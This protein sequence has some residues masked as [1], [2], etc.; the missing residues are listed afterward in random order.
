MLCGGL[1]GETT[2]FM[3]RVDSEGIL[4]QDPGA[5]PLAETSWSAGFSGLPGFKIESETPEDDMKIHARWLQTTNQPLAALAFVGWY[6]M[7][8]GRCSRY[9]AHGSE[10]IHE[11][12]D[13]DYT[14]YCMTQFLEAITC[15][16]DR[17]HMKSFCSLYRIARE[18]LKRFRHCDDSLP[19][20]PIPDICELHHYLDRNMDKK[21]LLKVMLA[22]QL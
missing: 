6:A 13:P 14:P 20:V 2:C 21:Q 8:S 11:P 7:S 22:L 3:F 5:V 12:Q 16:F 4:V 10:R 9:R 19:S 1:E 15:D 17:R 18:A